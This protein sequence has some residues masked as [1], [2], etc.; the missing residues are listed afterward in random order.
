MTQLNTL[1]FEVY[2]LMRKNSSP[3]N[4]EGRQYTKVDGDLSDPA[5]LR[6]AV[7]GMNYIFHVAGVTAATDPKIFFESNARGTAHIAEAALE[8]SSTLKRFVYV[9]SLAAGGPTRTPEPRKESHP[10][11][12]LSEYGKSKREGELE[13]LK[14]K[15]RYPVVIV[16]PPMV[17]G[18]KDKDVFVMIQSVA[19][20]LMPLLKGSTPDGRKLYSAIHSEDLCRG[21]MQAALAPAHAFP[22]GEVFYL[23][24][25]GIYSYQEIMETAARILEKDPL[26]ISIPKFMVRIA[27]YLNTGVSALTGKKSPLTI[28]KLNEILPDYWM[29]SNEKAKK[30]LNFTP[31]Y[32]L[33]NGMAH[34]IKWYKL[35]KWL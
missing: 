10:D 30:I 18:P 24:G 29:C 21:I 25:D 13:L 7:L 3:S 17:Y 4:L 26:R 16:R 22:S 1:G 5:S 32:D 28:D 14:Y 8:A 11:E 12:P 35:Q 27:A 19:R 34:T 9:S 33:Q 6:R 31:E 15:D 23:S 20:G 2:A